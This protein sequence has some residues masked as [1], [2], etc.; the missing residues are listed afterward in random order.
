MP[1]SILI[2]EDNVVHGDMMKDLMRAKG[3]DTT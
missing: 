2:V 3:Y 1:K